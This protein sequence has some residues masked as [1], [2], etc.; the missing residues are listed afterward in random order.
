[1][2]ET[3]QHI[4]EEWIAAWNAH[5]LDAIMAHY[6]EDI[7]F[8]SP[9]IVKRLGIA[10]GKLEGKAALRSYFEKGLASIPDLHFTLLQVLPG[11]GSLTIYY[12]NQT[13]AEVAEV[14]VLDADQCAV[15]V[16]AHYSPS[17]SVWA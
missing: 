1:M 16:R 11:V 15:Q 7:E 10:R 2:I 3:A 4:A 8:W 17:S 12:R 14:T 6:A 9:L 5:D 13:G